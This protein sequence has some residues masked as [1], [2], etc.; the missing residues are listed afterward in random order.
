MSRRAVALSMVAAVVIGVAAAVVWAWL[1]EPAQWQIRENGVV[2]TEGAAKAQFSVVVVFVLIGM[3]SS[4]VA[5]L[6]MGW[7][8]DALGWV[9]VPLAIALTLASGLIA[10]QLG[11]QLGPPDPATASG[12]SVGDTISAQLEI[13]AIA[14]FLAWPI[15]G[16]L[17]V[18]VAACIDRRSDHD[19]QQSVAAG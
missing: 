1:A 9:V 14:P 5:G 19:A 13:D 3:V 2:L 10:W 11:V 12:G 6:A 4:I 7:F 17:G 18:V 15:A 16:L 8:L